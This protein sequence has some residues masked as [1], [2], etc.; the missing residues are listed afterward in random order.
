[1]F[2]LKLTSRVF[3]RSLKHFSDEG[4]LWS[5]VQNPGGGGRS[6]EV[7]KVFGTVYVAVDVTLFVLLAARRTYCVFFV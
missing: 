1:M 2:W 4:R 3:K 7:P 6:D 5:V